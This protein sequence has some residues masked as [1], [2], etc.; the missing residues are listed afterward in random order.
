[1]SMPPDRKKC[2][3]IDDGNFVK[4][5]VYT[6]EELA[7]HNKEG[8]IWIAIDGEVFDV[9]EW[10]DRHPGGKLVVIAVAGKDVSLPFTTTHPPW[11][12]NMLPKFK[13]GVLADSPKSSLSTDYRD[14]LRRMHSDGIFVPELQPY[15]QKL[16]I[17][18]TMLL[19]VVYLVVLGRSFVGHLAAAVI[20]GMFW[21]QLA[22]IGHDCGHNAVL[23]NRRNDMRLGRVITCFFGVGGQ[24]WKRSHNV[25][26][27]VTNSIDFDSDI[28]HLPVFAV[29]KQI[30]GGFFSKYHSKPFKFNTIAQMMVSYQHIMYFPVMA[31]SRFNM[32]F[33]A[34][35]LVMN[36]SLKVE[37]RGPEIVCLS[38]YAIW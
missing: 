37:S 9:S 12:V 3:A 17:F 1:M 22:L 31:V 7:K 20:L 2:S 36:P 16:L 4:S 23:Y 29:T 6:L 28:Q 21:Q 26:H 35:K 14:T 34:W 24:W 10:V 13:I 32:Y 5:Q 38:V 27:L 8:D 15:W 25:H 18:S 19:T 33:Q 30:F 11:V